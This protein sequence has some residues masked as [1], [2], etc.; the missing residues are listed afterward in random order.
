MPPQ[1]RSNTMPTITPA[2]PLP[3]LDHHREIP[4]PSVPSPTESRSSAENDL[5][6]RDVGY[7]LCGDDHLPGLGGRTG[8][9]FVPKFRT[10]SPSLPNLSARGRGYVLDTPLDYESDEEAEVPSG[11]GWRV[12]DW[13]STSDEDL[14]EYSGSDSELSEDEE[15]EPLPE[16]LLR[17]LQ[18]MTAPQSQN[19]A[20]MPPSV[21]PK[22]SFSLDGDYELQDYESSDEFDRTD[23]APRVMDKRKSMA[24]VE[25]RPTATKRRSFPLRPGGAAL[26]A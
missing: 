25:K 16:H 6:F 4:S 10:R 23:S 17:R 9:E 26:Y 22:D 12:D 19:S 2:A 5:L 21:R 3:T 14:D 18:H 8:E 11:D 7:G 1:P 15:N 13:T 20:K 24:G